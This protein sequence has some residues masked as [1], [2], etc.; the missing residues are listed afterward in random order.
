MRTKTIRFFTRSGKLDYP[1]AE[2]TKASKK[3]VKAMKHLT[4][5]R[6]QHNPNNPNNM[7]IIPST[8]IFNRQFVDLLRKIFVYN[9]KERIT[10]KEALKHPWFEC[11]MKDDGTE[12]LGLRLKR[13]REKERAEVVNLDGEGDG[14]EGDYE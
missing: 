8:S 7:E 9:P 10:A 12:A 3:Y 1:N 14:G 11:A 4:D 13:E 6:A 2:T 5:P